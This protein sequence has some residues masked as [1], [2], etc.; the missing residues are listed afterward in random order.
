[1]L[2]GEVQDATNTDKPPLHYEIFQF[3]K[4][5][6][7]HL[8]AAIPLALVSTLLHETAHAVAVWVQGG[9]V[10]EFVWFP[11]GDNWGHVR[12]SFPPD[13]VYSDFFISVA[14]YLFWTL[15]AATCVVLAF[16]LPQPVSFRTGSIL[17]IWL[18]V[19][20]LA[21]IGYAA[22]PYLQG[23][24]NDFLSAFG[25]P[26]TGMSLLIYSG[27]LV[28]MAIGF[29][30]HR[31]LYQDAKLSLPAYLILAWLTVGGLHL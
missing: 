25:P 28:A 18:Y 1:M 16:L 30:V 5:H 29:F 24:Q 13:R 23:K 4:W 3:V 12:Y 14:P 9:T 21:D 17:Y 31:T 15:C 11:S 2:V 19:A 8:V 20:P 26:G 22:F 7:P 27:V 6:W 10:L